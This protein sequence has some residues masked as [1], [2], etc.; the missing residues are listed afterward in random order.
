MNYQR[1]FGFCGTLVTREWGLMRQVL[2][3]GMKQQSA[4][5]PACA[6]KLR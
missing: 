2:G 4:T 3:E 5:D 1:V 6:L